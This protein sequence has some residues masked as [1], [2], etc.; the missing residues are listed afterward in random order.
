MEVGF[1]KYIHTKGGRLD[2]RR[3][4]EDRGDEGRQKRLGVSFLLLAVVHHHSGET[5]MRIYI[6]MLAYDR[7]FGFPKNCA[8]SYNL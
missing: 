1:N 5:R 2:K 3:S 4:T 7:I 6:Y 8:D